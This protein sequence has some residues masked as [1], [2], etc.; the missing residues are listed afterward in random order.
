MKKRGR[1]KKEE[2]HFSHFTYTERLQIEA[3]LKT[4]TP[5]KTIAELL[6]KDQS[7]IYR[8]IKR[9]G[10]DRLNGDDYSMYRAYSPDIAETRYRENIKAKGAPLKIGSDLEYAEYIEKKII[11]DKYSPKAV[12]GEIKQKGL[13]FRTTISHT[14]LYRYIDEGLFL[15]LTNKDLPVKR[16]K[17]KQTYR[18][19]KPARPPKGESIEKRPK[20][21]AERNTFGNWEMDCVIGT[22]TGGNVLL[23]LT[24]R[25][26]RREYVRLMP[27]KH[28]TNVV[29]VLDNI[30][31]KLGSDMFTKIFKT[32]TVDNGSEFSDHEGMERSIGGGKR[33]KVYFC[34]PYSSYERGSNENLNKMVRRWYPK[35]CSFAKVT[36]ENIADLEKWMN[37]YP[38][39]IFGYDTS[40][41]MYRRE[42]IRLSG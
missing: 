3:W 22:K 18:K 11:K 9:G 31:K 25:L 10:Y 24:E 12:L 42:I 30:E 36:D 8:E 1:K 15:H 23:V 41:E 7:S 6:H 29:R 2:K 19:V 21:V 4:K 40:A 35:G 37:E 33:T 34:H 27:S 20:E 16:N 28:M 13:K 17:T 14:T 5:V 39:G 38:R 26:T 32:I